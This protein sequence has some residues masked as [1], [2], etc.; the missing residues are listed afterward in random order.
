MKTIIILFSLF[1]VDQSQEADLQNDFYDGGSQCCTQTY[2]VGTPGEDGYVSMSRT[3]CVTGTSNQAYL[4]ACNKASYA[5][6]RMT[7]ILDAG[8]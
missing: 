6:S 1:F 2:T 5:L 4:T 3:E 7:A 8:F